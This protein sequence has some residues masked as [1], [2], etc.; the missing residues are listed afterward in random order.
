M[1]VKNPLL[2]PEL[3]QLLA[4]GNTTS[5]QYFCDTSHPALVADLIDALEPD[6]IWAVI[7]QAEAP[8]RGD[9]FSHLDEDTQ[10][11]MLQT[12][13]RRDRA[14]LLAS[15]APDD[16]AD[17]FKK[18][19]E[20]MAETVLPALAHAEREDIRRLTAHEEGTAGAVMTS[21]YVALSPD[22]SV[23]Q[24]L[25]RLR[26]VA[27]DRETIYYCYI[28]GPERRLMG[29][30]SLRDLILAPRE[31]LVSDIMQ[32]EV[33]FARV[34]DDQE[35]A[36][37]QIQKYDFIALPVVNQEDALV[38]I[39]THDDAIDIITQEHTEDME[40]IM[41][42]AGSHEA[43]VY[44]RTSSWTH[45]KNRSVWILGLA[46]LGLFS[47]IIIHRFEHTLMHLVILALYMPML[48]DTGG[49]TGSQ[50][51][52]VVI[53]ALALGEISPKDTFRVLYKELK[54]SAMLAVIL[55]LLSWAKVMF[56]SHGTEIPDGFT[57]ASIGGAIAAALCLQV[58]T[59]T[60]IGALLPLGAAKMNWDPAVVASPALTT[61]VDISGLLIYF[62]MAKWILGI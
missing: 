61:L 54:I 57:L 41:G 11:D 22:L 9:I 24:A 17:L 44:L 15:M 38:G 39:I 59:A 33:I 40:K 25:E 56:L 12:I 19:P 27:P 34:D 7:Q 42:I 2:V 36:A 8:I 21:D 20:E 1:T 26:E 43:G 48:A 58:V 4:S 55:G 47:G 52:S 31:S 30:V 28:V 6:E 3:R 32:P 46:G 37:G 18:M 29:I 60:L 49:N 50:S 10:I 13:S 5:I 62:F 16:R 45:F 23:Q 51:A 35:E 14:A 53:R